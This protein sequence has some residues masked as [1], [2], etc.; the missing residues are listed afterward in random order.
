VRWA[1]RTVPLLLTLFAAGAPSDAGASRGL[2]VARWLERPGVRLVAV[3]F[4]ATWCK[5]CMEAVPRWKALYAKY[6]SEGLRILVVAT[7]DPKGCTNTGWAPDELICDDQGTIAD[8]LGAGDALPAAFLWTWQ[9][10]LLAQRGHVEDVE[11]AI[12]EW[13]RT[14]PRVEVSASAIEKAAI[15]KSALQDLVRGKLNDAGKLHVVA[16]AEERAALQKLKQESLKGRYDEKLQCELGKELSANS[17]LDVRIQGAPDPRLHLTLLSAERGCLVSSSVVDWNPKN[18]NTSVAEGIAGLFQ[19]LRGELEMPASGTPQAKGAAVISRVPQITIA[20]TGVTALNVEAERLLEAAMDAQESKGLGADQKEQ[21]WCALA[22][23]Q[24]NNPYEKDAKRACA[25]WRAYAQ[26]Y[27][28]LIATLPTEYD[29]L[30]GL[31]RLKRRTPEEKESALKT[32]LERYG[33]EKDPRVMVALRI[34][35]RW[36]MDAAAIERML[37]RPPPAEV[38]W[39]HIMEGDYPHPV[40]SIFPTSGSGSS[41]GT[42]WHEDLALGPNGLPAK[43]VTTWSN[44]TTTYTYTYDEEGYL[45]TEVMESSNFTWRREFSFDD[46]GRLHQVHVTMS[47]GGEPEI[48]TLS[49]DEPGRLNGWVTVQAGKVNARMVYTYGEDGRVAT[50]V[51]TLGSDNPTT[52]IYHHYQG[53]IDQSCS[54]YVTYTSYR[55]SDPNGRLTR[56]ATTGSYPS[57]ITYYYPR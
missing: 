52:C 31:L 27:R 44:T 22:A 57:D 7:R 30:I 46:A 1:P 12:E 48:Q 4:Y 42:P 47:S 28:R 26:T 21:A 29:T 2:D 40:Q 41:N 54:G 35:K 9:G 6:R 38:A 32:F 56:I 13:M 24:K 50:S 25:E 55:Y 16:T 33:A 14:T 23:Y 34:Q 5:P 36:P 37:N 39:R 10:Q 19:G 45:K 53:R 51:N 15:S 43:R 8:A 18:S 49:Y 20:S 3:E 11:H 17:L